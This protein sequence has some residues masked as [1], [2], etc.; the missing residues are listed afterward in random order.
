MRTAPNRNRSGSPQTALLNLGYRILYD[1]MISNYD[2]KNKT[3][4]SRMFRRRAD[5]N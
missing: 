3:A 1:Y 5:P 2:Q 4:V